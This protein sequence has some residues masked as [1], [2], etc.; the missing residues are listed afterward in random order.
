MSYYKDGPVSTVGCTVQ[1]QFCDAS[2][3]ASDLDRCGTLNGDY[4]DKELE[5]IW[6]DDYHRERMQ[7][8]YRILHSNA[9]SIE[10]IVESLGPEAL[11]AR[12]TLRGQYQSKLPNHHWQLEMENLVS[13]SLVSLQ[14]AFVEAANGQSRP[15][16]KQILERPLRNNTAQMS[17]CTSQVR[18]ILLK[19]LR[20]II[21]SLLTHIVIEN[22]KHAI[23]VF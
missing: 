2:R 18:M 10:N 7:W 5:R 14:A 12:Y 21:V 6:K 17:M 11:L 19:T 20:N 23:L 16:M 22:Q 13:V 8:V 4:D 3:P 15:G 1:S 9:D